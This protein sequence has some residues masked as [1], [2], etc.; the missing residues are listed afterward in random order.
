MLPVKASKGLT[1]CFSLAEEFETGGGPEQRAKRLSELQLL[2]IILNAASH[3]ERVKEIRQDAQKPGSTTRLKSHV[4]LQN[5]RDLPKGTAAANLLCFVSPVISCTTA[6]LLVR[7]VV[8]AT[9]CP[10]FRSTSIRVSNFEP[11][12]LPNSVCCVIYPN[13][14]QS[15]FSCLPSA[16]VCLFAFVPQRFTCQAQAY[17]V[18][19][20]WRSWRID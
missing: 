2:S 7:S 9:C 19:L 12:N 1:R 18:H 6:T 17:Q 10:N 8:C 16:H 13:C 14:R 11:S 20:E 15:I 5:L 3:R 4:L